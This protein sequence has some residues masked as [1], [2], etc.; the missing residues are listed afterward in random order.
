MTSQAALTREEL[1]AR[2]FER[3]EQLEQRFLRQLE[4][5][6]FFEPLSLQLQATVDAGGT[7]QLDAAQLRPW[8]ER[9]V[10]TVVIEFTA[11]MMDTVF[12]D[13]E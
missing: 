7:A 4:S 5:V 6:G 9:S 8:L 1:A 13:E 3:Q 2:L 11:A 10:R 12:A